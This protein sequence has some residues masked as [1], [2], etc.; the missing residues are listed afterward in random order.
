MK[1]ELKRYRLQK[2]KNYFQ[3]NS[4]F[5]MYNVSN[6]NSKNWLKTEQVLHGYNLK[7]Y[8]IYNTLS[9]KFLKKSIFKNTDKLINSSICFIHFDKN[10]KDLTNFQKLVNLNPLVCM[11]GIR[12]ND[13]IYSTAQL[14]Q[15]STLNH[16]NNIKVLNK[17]LEKLLKLPYYKMKK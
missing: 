14:T 6:L 1:F 5:F 17:S 7:Y 8:K 3:K 16:T 2:T 13:K 4:I 11:L 12:L 15:I 10:N 9:K